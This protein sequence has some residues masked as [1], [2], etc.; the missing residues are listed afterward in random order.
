MYL[1]RKLSNFEELKWLLK[2]SL[3]LFCKERYV[4]FGPRMKGINIINNYAH[5]HGQGIRWD[6]ISILAGDESVSACAIMLPTFRLVI[7]VTRLSLFRIHAFPKLCDATP[8]CR[9]GG[10]FYNAYNS[11]VSDVGQ[12]T[13]HVLIRVRPSPV[14]VFGET[15]LVV[16]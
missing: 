8:G 2:I 10:Q 11:P 14:I 13:P 12:S 4:L 9:S 16:R 3:H 15:S 5:S 6:I 7:T 1:M